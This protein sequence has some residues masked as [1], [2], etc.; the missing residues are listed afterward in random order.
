MSVE[1]LGDYTCSLFICAD[2]EFNS[3]NTPPPYR[4]VIFA[5]LLINE[6]LLCKKINKN[7]DER[8][9]GC[10]AKE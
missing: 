1:I 8:C 10:V 5:L 4:G 2:C 9:Y 6:A 7:E 3:G